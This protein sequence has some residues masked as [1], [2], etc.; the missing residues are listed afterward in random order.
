MEIIAIGNSWKYKYFKNL[1]TVNV[2][3]ANRH[4]DVLLL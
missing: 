2:I 1:G 3:L 4:A